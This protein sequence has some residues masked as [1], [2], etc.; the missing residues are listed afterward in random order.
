MYSNDWRSSRYSYG[1]GGTRD[2]CASVLASG[3]ATIASRVVPRLGPYSQ[4]T[5]DG[6]QKAFGTAIQAEPSA[7]SAITAAFEQNANVSLGPVAAPL[8]KLF[9]QSLVGV[10]VSQNNL[11]FI[12]TTF[13]ADLAQ[14]LAPCKDGSGSL[15]AGAPAPI[16]MPA[17][18]VTEGDIGV[19]AK[20]RTWF[21][22]EAGRLKVRQPC[23]KSVPDQVGVAAN[24]QPI[25]LTWKTVQDQCE[26]FE[27]DPNIAKL[28]NQRVQKGDITKKLPTTFVAIPPSGAASGGGSMTVPLVAGAAALAAILLLRK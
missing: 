19:D 24:G 6:V 16:V 5:I 15:R 3:L 10:D 28:V 20:G 4:A 26:T 14:I 27:V 1:F 2:S 22:D 23:M 12:V 13:I 25:T 17:V 8:V 21:Y 11:E 7:V 18:N 9:V